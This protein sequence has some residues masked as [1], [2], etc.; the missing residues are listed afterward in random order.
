MSKS[1]Y[2]RG[3]EWRKWD[4]HIHTPASFHW[5]GGKRF[6]EMTAPEKEQAFQ[7]MLET[8]NNSDVAA[9]A[10]TDYWTFDGYLE[11]KDYIKRKN[12]KLNKTVFPGMELRVEAPVDY[13][14]NIQV[15]LSDELTA[16]Q[17]KDFKAKLRIGSLNRSLSDDAIK[18]FAQTLDDSKAKTHGFK[19][20]S[21]LNDTELLELG[22]KTVVV[23]KESLCRDAFTAIPPKCGYILLP[24]D[25]SD[26]LVKL[27]WA[28]HP[29]DDN[30]F[31]QS[32]HIFES[33]ND[34]CIDLFLCKET[35][36]N[37]S[38]I[39]NFIKTIGG[40]PKPV[41]S[42]SDAHKIE[43]YGNY[44]SGKITW[45]KADV[46]FQGL[47]QV[48]NEP[49][50]RAYVGTSPLKLIEVANNKSKYVDSIKIAHTSPGT[51]PAWFSS[52]LPL[53]SGFVAIIGKKGSGKSALADIV[54]LCGDSKIN[55]KDYSFLT[56]QKFK[57][58][59]L[60]KNYEA[61]LTWLDAQEI[62]KNLDSEVEVATS[63][64]RIKY[65]P[66]QYVETICNEEGVSILFQQEIDKVIFS[67]VPDE[68]RLGT[69]S[70][71][72]LIKTKTESVDGSI[73][74]LRTEL[75]RINEKI[76]LHED[77]EAPKYEESLNK[78][79]EEKQ[80]ELKN[81]PQP[82]VVKKPKTTLNKATEA[83]IKRLTA[84]I[85]KFDEQITVAK[86]ELKDVN[87]RL[88][89]LEKITDK[90][91]SLGG[92]VEAFIETFQ[93]DAT[94][95]GIDLTKVLSLKINDGVLKTKKTELSAEKE[96]LDEKLEQ[97]NPKST[98]SFYIKKAKQEAELAK[99]T[100]T[101]DADQKQ[102]KE[103]LQALKEYGEKKQAI[104]GK[105]GDTSL[106]TIISLEEE[107]DFVKNKL[108]GFLQQGYKKRE[109]TLKKVFK[110]LGQKIK[111]YQEI[112]TPI[113]SFIE[114]EK[115]TQE[116]SGNVLSFSAGLV[117]GRPKFVDDFFSFV[118]Q[119]KDGSFQTVAGGQKILNAIMDKYDLTKEDGVC[120]FTEDLLTHLRND[121]TGTTP[122][123]NHIKSQ[124]KKDQTDFYDY[125]FNLD[126]LDV[127]YKILFNGKDLNANEF[128]PGEKG[129][130][131]LIFYL[132]I[133]KENIP[134]V[135]DQPEEN[136]DNESV[137][138]LLVPYIK[139]A[140]SRRQ[141]IAVTHNPNL[142]VVCDAEQ[143]I[144][145]SMDKKKSEVKYVSGSIEDSDINKKIVDILEGT[146]P[147]FTVRDRSYIRR[148]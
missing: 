49:A 107:I 13:R 90:V 138:T 100:A 15:I 11:F 62:S 29:H 20:P 137:Y 99:I 125:V 31:M 27:D 113:V 133:D 63:V 26:G 58:R 30:Y 80:R 81:L 84:S 143:I 71:A 109:E 119:G 145:A 53:N 97:N 22:S 139:K 79:L 17:L 2:N 88:H 3:S 103:Y 16:Q 146:L 51:T 54:S 72:E 91:T 41:V 68:S 87:G 56:T 108:K 76:T 118:N 144:C 61:N 114:S 7:K 116:K 73:S 82:K 43:D 141:I 55:P 128:S 70:L 46:T 140:K 34:E 40:K 110:E 147:A 127:K 33:R 12:L 4:L 148:N 102:Y 32:A 47:R 104:E 14:L 18:E 105:K 78:K 93:E 96:K 6:F 21:T 1:L 121:N 135:I 10:M 57:K 130:L 60:A 52:K 83:K 106:D 124:L 24:Y 117:F 23:T 75:H 8:I 65:L 42:G 9:F 44:P 115:E 132:L 59:S 101:L 142:A 36:K 112:Y 111:F 134:L 92:D 25:T 48:V 122:K 126:Y 77:K 129:A 19:S 74:V 86:Q 5:N 94:G 123:T 50:D 64:E 131:L 98:T 95:M 28:T 136:L 67:Y 45:I 39:K 38:F 120:G 89:K 66:Q 69:N 37:K 85:T 35:P